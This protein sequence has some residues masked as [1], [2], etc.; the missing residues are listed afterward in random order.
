MVIGARITSMDRAEAEGISIQA[1]AA[2]TVVANGMPDSM[3]N[4]N[5]NKRLLERDMAAKAKMGKDMASRVDG[6]S[7]S[8]H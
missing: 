3:D 1:S 6:V 4:I 5:N 8:A 2:D 7:E